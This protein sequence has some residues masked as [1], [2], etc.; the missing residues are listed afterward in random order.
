MMGASKG[1]KHT[2][3]DTANILTLPN[4]IAISKQHANRHQSEKNISKK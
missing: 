4:Y 1:F 2:R 3:I